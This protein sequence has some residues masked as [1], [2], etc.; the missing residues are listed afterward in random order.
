MPT[1]RWKCE[2]EERN[3]VID[4]QIAAA[5]RTGE[6]ARTVI[7]DHAARMPLEKLATLPPNAIALLGRGGLAR[8]VARKSEIEW[9]AP[10]AP[11]VTPS[12]TSKASVMAPETIFA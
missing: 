10:V 7:V 2:I 11:P 1:E 12:P 8:V 3:R 6:E 9:R 4:R 5:I